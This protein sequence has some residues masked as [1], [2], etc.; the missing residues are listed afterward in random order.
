MVQREVVPEV[1]KKKQ[2]APQTLQGIHQ[3]IMEIGNSHA[4]VLDQFTRERKE[5]AID[6]VKPKMYDQ[7]FESANRKLIIGNAHKREIEKQKV[8][9][10]MVNLKK[11]LDKRE[12]E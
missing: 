3:R 12:K 4:E 2:N 5:D 1:Q 6:F 8:F 9:D 11:K 10:E 7:E